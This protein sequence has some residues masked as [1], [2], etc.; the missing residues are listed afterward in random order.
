MYSLQT[1]YSHTCTHVGVS[2]PCKFAGAVS[3]SQGGC[4][5]ACARHTATPAQGC[6]WANFAFLRRPRTRALTCCAR[7]DELDEGSTQ[8]CDAVCWRKPAQASVTAICRHVSQH[9]LHMQA[10]TEHGHTCTGS[11]QRLHAACKVLPQA[12][13]T[14]NLQVQRGTCLCSARAA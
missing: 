8:G 1:A 5:T 11:K 7:G 10:W 2:T 13:H 14:E 9:N 4:R 12:V 6:V 3:E